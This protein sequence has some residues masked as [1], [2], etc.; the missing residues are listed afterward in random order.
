MKF[1]IKWFIKDAQN[2]KDS[3]V[4]DLYGRICSSVGIILNLLLFGM[5]FIVGTLFHSVSIQADAFNNLSDAGSSLVSLVSFFYASRPAD[6]EHPFGHERFEYIGSL[7]VSF[8]ILF[9][10]FELLLSSI[11]AI[12]HPSALHFDALMCVV[13]VVSMLVKF[14]M[15]YY[16]S[17]YGKLIHSS[18]MKATALDSIS[19]VMATGAILVALLISLW[20]NINLDGFMGVV[21]ACIIAK[22]GYELVK[23]TL[24]KLMGEAPSEELIECIVNKVL[25]YDGILGIHDLVVHSYGANKIFATLHAEVSANADILESHDLMDIIERDFKENEH[26][27]MVLH[28]DPIV[29]D[30]AF[31]NDLREKIGTMIRD[32]DKQL[33]F[34][35]FRIVK[36][37]TH[38]NLIF[39]VVVPYDFKMSEDVL[40]KTIKERIPQNDDGVVNLAVITIDH[41]YTHT[42]KQKDNNIDNAI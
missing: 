31:T 9:F 29:I 21:V 40:V 34:H 25:S 14:Y 12:M 4:R 30:D 18:V 1:L 8:I 16:N 38:N 33:S 19:D 20:T 39:D 15:Y 37:P 28:M 5:K 2:I 27:D 32:I 24:D 23:E 35:D 22:A 41:S 13:L 26:I 17:H 42:P 3:R 11:D 6:E 36:G 7:I 10:S